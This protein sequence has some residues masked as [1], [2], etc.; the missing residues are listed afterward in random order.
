LAGACSP[1]G[2][3]PALRLSSA[4]DL[5]HAYQLASGEPNHDPQKH[6]ISWNKWKDVESLAKVF[7]DAGRPFTNVTVHEKQ[8]LADCVYIRNRIAHSSQK[9]KADFIKVAKPHLG[10]NPNDK[11]PKGFSS[12][13]LLL[14]SSSTLFGANASQKPFFEHYMDVVNSCANR[15]CPK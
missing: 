8:R 3:R 13:Q 14:T 5:V 15:I 7:F 1:S 4:K 9:C 6:F 12:G 2:Y 10:L 11:L